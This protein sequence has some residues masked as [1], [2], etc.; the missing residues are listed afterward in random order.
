MS[1]LMDEQAMAVHLARA[2]RQLMSQLILSH[3]PAFALAFRLD[4]A[5]QVAR[6]MCRVACARIHSTSS[7]P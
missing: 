6:A 2:D 1:L 7:S 3:G 4:F 5:E